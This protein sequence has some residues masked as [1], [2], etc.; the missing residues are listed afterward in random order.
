MSCGIPL[1]ANEVLAKCKQCE[2]NME[3]RINPRLV[4]QL[5]DETAAIAKGQVIWSDEAWLRLLGHSPKELAK[6]TP[7]A[8]TSL[9][10]QLLFL[11]IVIAFV[12]SP[13]VEKIAIL[14]VQDV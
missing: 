4:G 10:H 8:L 9:E 3:L 2:K 6:A 12:W 11:R 5:L 14:R 7:E 13:T 1:Y